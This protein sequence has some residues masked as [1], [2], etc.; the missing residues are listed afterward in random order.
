MAS[1]SK[2]KGDRMGHERN[3]FDAAFKAT[4]GQY[5]FRMGK[6]EMFYQKDEIMRPYP[7]LTE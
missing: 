7:A 4:N 5:F 2:I 1:N 6:P 3:V